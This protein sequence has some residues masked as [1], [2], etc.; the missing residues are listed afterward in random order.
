MTQLNRRTFLQQGTASAAVSALAGTALFPKEAKAFQSFPTDSA[1]LAT[2]DGVLELV[3]SMVAYGPRLTGNAAHKSYVNNLAQTF[4]ELGLQ[5]TRDTQVFDRWEVKDFSLKVERAGKMAPVTLAGYHPYSGS[6]PAEG[7]KGKLAYLGQLKLPTL[8]N[9]A[10]FKSFDAFVQAIFQQLLPGIVANAA[11]LAGGIKGA[12]VLVEVPNLPLIAGIADVVKSHE[13]DPDN[14]IQFNTSYR[15]TWINGFLTGLADVYKGMGAAGIVYIL[16]ASPDNAKGQ[17]I[18]FFSKLK[19]FPGVLVDRVVGNQLR[20]QAAFRANANL[21]LTANIEKNATSD[22]LVAI[23]PGCSAE[24]IVINTH[25]D[26]QNAFE[27]NGAAAC[28]ALARY[29]AAK[30][31]E[32]RQRTLVFSC[33]TGHMVEGLPQAQGFI[34]AHPEL[35]SRSVASLTIEHFGATEWLDSPIYGY[36]ATGNPEIAGIFHTGGLLEAAIA[37]VKETDLRRTLLLKPIF[38]VFFGVGYPLAQAGIP[39]LAYIAGPEYLVAIAPDGHLNKF[40]KKRMR[41]E[42]QW[43][44][45]VLRR[46]EGMTAAQLKG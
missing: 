36:R 35:I 8:P 42:L 11:S 40:D 1:G 2:E 3:Q 26:G 16:D 21:T 41:R 28:V 6:T 46:I 18:P 14:T 13:Y 38:G 45:D 20:L 22:S 10:D 17:Y 12:I 29:Y 25:T 44:V 39:T 34:D 24:N 19:Q 4:A 5:V 31:I 15:R 23:L 27:E 9:L 32:Q 30:P 33:V 37:A 7:I 43:C